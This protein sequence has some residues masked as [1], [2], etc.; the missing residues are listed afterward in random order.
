MEEAA[1]ET[2]WFLRTMHGRCMF[3]KFLS[4]WDLKTDLNAMG[5]GMQS[6]E[7]CMCFIYCC[8]LGLWGFAALRPSPKTVHT[9]FFYLEN[10][11]TNALER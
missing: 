1:L 2:L 7:P 8:A 5:G 3:A 6:F 11:Q 4:G 9:F 10:L